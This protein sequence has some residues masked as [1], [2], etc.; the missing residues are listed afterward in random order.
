MSARTHNEYCGY[1][2]QIDC[3]LV[4]EHHVWTATYRITRASDG[5]LATY[6]VISG[7]FLSPE[8]ASAGAKDA[9]EFWVDRQ[10]QI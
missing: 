7:Q 6:G 8:D 4:R 10:A 1:D 5:A 3:H 2:I 9:A